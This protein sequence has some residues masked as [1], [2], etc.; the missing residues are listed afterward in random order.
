MDGACSDVYADVHRISRDVPVVDQDGVI[1]MNDYICDM[2]LAVD[3]FH[4]VSGKMLH[5]IIGMK[6][7]GR[8]LSED[9]IISA[10]CQNI[11]TLEEEDIVFIH[12][13]DNVQTQL[14]HVEMFYESIKIKSMMSNN[15]PGLYIIPNMELFKQI[16]NMT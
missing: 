2:V 5:K 11:K 8:K 9:T 1:K 15:K 3:Y 14:S 4:T 10:L 7:N 13:I 6:T 16:S 12:V